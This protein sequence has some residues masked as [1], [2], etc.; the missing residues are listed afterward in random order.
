MGDSKT[1]AHEDY[2]SIHCV[3]DVDLMKLYEISIQ[4]H[5]ILM[6]FVSNYMFLKNT[7]IVG[8]KMII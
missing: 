5:N 3:V 8:L 4:N 2:T 7:L 1:R 6:N